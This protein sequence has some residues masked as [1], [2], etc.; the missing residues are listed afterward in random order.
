MEAR[1]SQSGIGD[2]VVALAETSSKGAKGLTGTVTNP[3]VNEAAASLKVVGRGAV[4]F[5]V[6]TSAYT[7][8]TAPEGERG[9]TAAG[10]A[11]GMAGG[12]AGAWA[13]AKVGAAFGSL[14]G[15]EGT[16]IGGVLGALG[17]GFVGGKAG[18]DVGTQCHDELANP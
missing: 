15:P 10:E 5:S 9:R 17:G 14:F 13:G 1:A 16:A 11:G 3:G 8:A 2:G 18:Q 12:F 7:V 6:A 4:A